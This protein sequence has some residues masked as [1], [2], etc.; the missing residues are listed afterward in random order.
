[1][2]NRGW[3]VLTKNSEVFALE[4]DPADLPLMRSELA[5]VL[6]TIKTSSDLARTIL[7]INKDVEVRPAIS[8]LLAKLL[9]VRLKVLEVQ[10]NLQQQ[11]DE[12]NKLREQL[13]EREGWR[14]E[15]KRYELFHPD[16][17]QIVYRLRAEHR[18]DGPET[19]FCP[20][21]F[22]TECRISILQMWDY[23]PGTRVCHACGFQITPGVRPRGRFE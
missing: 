2:V 14:E 17:A 22:I 16:E 9:E 8:E 12:L 23:R 11:A 3:R 19:W 21:C 18:G 20:H 13:R 4:L 6:A 10:G 5:S 15:A 1:M 7:N